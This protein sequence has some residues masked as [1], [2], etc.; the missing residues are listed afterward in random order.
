MECEFSNHRNIF[1]IC[2]AFIN[3]KRKKTTFLIPW[4]VGGAS[5]L[6]NFRR[7]ETT[8]A[9]GL[10]I[11]NKVGLASGFKRFFLKLRNMT[12]SK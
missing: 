4:R 12:S 3:S 7:F 2:E 1:N 11:S 10:G 6:C 8:F 9:G 5:F